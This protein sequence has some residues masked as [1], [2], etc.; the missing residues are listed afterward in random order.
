MSPNSCILVVPPMRTLAFPPLGVS[1]LKANLAAQGFPTDILFA[2][3]RLA[4]E[5]SVGLQFFI[6]GPGSPLVDP[7]FAHPLFE[8]TDADLHELVERF[9]KHARGVVGFLRG[10]YPSLT[11]HRV[12]SR[13]VEVGRTLGKGIAAEIAARAP[14]LLGLSSSM[15]DNSFC[16]YVAREVKRLTPETITVL[17]GANCSDTMGQELFARF[18]EIDYMCQGDAD[19]SLFELAR[20]LQR[21]RRLASPIRGV[22]CREHPA[23]DVAPAAQV[24]GDELTSLPDPDFSDFLQQTQRVLNKFPDTR[25]LFDQQGFLVLT[26]ETSR[27]CWWGAKHRCSFC[28]LNACLTA[29]SSKAPH[30]VHEQLR[31]LV[32]RYKPANIVIVDNLP[33]PEYFKNLWPRLAE[34]PLVPLSMETTGALTREQM[35]LL[36]RAGVIRIQPGI[37]SLSDHAIKI[38]GKPTT[39]VRSIA[40]LKWCASLGVEVAWNY[41]Y[42][43][44]G[45]RPEEVDQ[46]QQMIPQL[47]HLPPPVGMSS[48]DVTRFS[49][50]FEDPDK[51]GLAPLLVRELQR[52]IYPFPEESIRRLSY[53]FDSEY[54]REWRR[55]EAWRKMTRVIMSWHQAR[56]RSHLLYSRRRDGGAVVIDTRPARKR[57]VHRLTAVEAAVC[58]ACDQPRTVEAVREQLGARWGEEEVAAALEGLAQE[59][60]LLQHG[61]RV[62]NLA[63][64]PTSHYPRVQVEQPEVTTLACAS[65][66]EFWRFAGVIGV[67]RS[68]LL[69][70]TLRYLVFKVV[71]S[72]RRARWVVLS[73]GLSALAAAL[74]TRRGAAEPDR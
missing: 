52:G 54:F 67:A 49:N 15:G 53:F 3:C 16:L 31:R 47:S 68:R 39:P 58:E 51:Y 43:V 69:V 28:G 29:H 73:R 9:D 42:G 25:K 6:S 50:Y 17:G 12:L 35:E 26:A 46:L 64:E 63:V 37:E 33:S 23:R 45:E 65:V 30:A 56:W 55:S 8:R 74:T 71:V 27:G 62:L 5:Y 24:T 72:L 21:D 7:M 41:L 22:L 60:L 70:D 1:L 44:P 18:P 11:T 19:R 34:S 36:A 14:W 10:L 61:E 4:E 48:I 20:A 32:E 40:T 38:M 66:R 2:N 57:L 59:G 13:L